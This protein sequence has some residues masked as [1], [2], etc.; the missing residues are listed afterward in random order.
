MLYITYIQTIAFS[1]SLLFR[2]IISSSLTKLVRKPVKWNQKAVRMI[3]TMLALTKW[4]ELRWT[5]LRIKY[6]YGVRCVYEY[7]IYTVHTLPKLNTVMRTFHG[8]ES[9]VYLMLT[10]PP[11]IQMRKREKGKMSDAEV[12]EKF[13][14]LCSPMNPEAVYDRDKELGAG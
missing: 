4:T 3:P 10:I 9:T 13:T 1:L 6:R 2:L 11:F 5:P 12:M 8:I 7:Q 14:Q